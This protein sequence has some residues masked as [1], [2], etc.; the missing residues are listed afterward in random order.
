MVGEAER[1]FDEFPVRI[2][3]VGRE[4]P[5]IPQA[6]G[7]FFNSIMRNGALSVREKEL[8]AVAVSMAV[9]C[10]PCI[11]AHTEKAI[12]AGATRKQILEAAGV[13]VLMQGAPSY[14][15]LP[16]LMDALDAVEIREAANEPQ[17]AHADS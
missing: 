11:N 15:Y 13:V 3:E 2:R 4:V 9:R 12:E 8:I 5:E 7:V 16:H 14:T 10:A 17:C 1:F 6:F